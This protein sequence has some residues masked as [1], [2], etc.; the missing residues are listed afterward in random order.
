MTR[1]STL[2]LAVPVAPGCSAKVGSP[3]G[4]KRAGCGE[5]SVGMTAWLQDMP[6]L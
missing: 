2:G 5:D 1:S 3:W 4:T 6:E